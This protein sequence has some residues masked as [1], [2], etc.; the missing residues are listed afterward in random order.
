MGYPVDVIAAYTGHPVPAALSGII[1]GN[2]LIGETI[3]AQGTGQYSDFKKEGT[4]AIVK[5]VIGN[6]LQAVQG[7]KVKAVYEAVIS[8]IIDTYIKD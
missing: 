7:K 3:I 2:T 1:N 5:E 6:T 8:T 4:S